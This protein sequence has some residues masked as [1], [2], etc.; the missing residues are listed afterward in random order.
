MCAIGRVAV[1]L[2]LF[3]SIARAEDAPALFQSAPNFSNAIAGAGF[4][5]SWSAD[6]T[7]LDSDDTVHLAITFL[8]ATNP[9]RIRRP[10]LRDR[11]AF[12]GSFREIVDEDPTMAPN[13]VTFH[14]RLRP[15]DTGVTEVP[16]LAIA[17]YSPGSGAVA[18]KYLDAI[19][20]VVHPPIVMPAPARP[21]EAPER[22]FA[23]PQ[24]KTR[25]QPG[26]AAWGMLAIGLLL[27]GS[28]GLAIQRYRDPG[29]RRLSRLR[30]VRAVRVAL[31]ALDRAG[32]SSDPTGAA[33]EALRGYLASR[34]GA[35]ATAATP[36]DF[37]QALA[38]ASIGPERIDAVRQIATVGDALRFSPER[39]PADLV[40]DI[41][42]LILDWEDSA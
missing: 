26:L 25:L 42:R 16:E 22:F 18:T 8:G 27:A 4:A 23:W 24:T 17:Y 7:K 6:P 19:P 40:P 5:V 9:D 10:A 13:A 2:L 15:R 31:D 34:H 28:F 36:G 20:L 39:T 37:V 35:L 38:A 21:I 11:P 32:R 41:R 30:R 29:S 14:Y 3:V 1:L 12:K 33:L